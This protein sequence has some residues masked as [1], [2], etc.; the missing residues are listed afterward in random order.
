[1][2]T[3]LHRDIEQAGG[4]WSHEIVPG[5]LGGSPDSRM[6]AISYGGL[7]HVFAQ[8]QDHSTY[9]NWQTAAGIGNWAGWSYLGGPF[10]GDP[11]AVKDLE[12]RANVFVCGLNDG[13]WRVRELPADPWW[14]D[15][16]SLGGDSSGTPA[17]LGNI[18]GT[19]EIFTRGTDG[20][21]YYR[22]QPLALSDVQAELVRAEAD[23]RSVAYRTLLA[24][25]GTSYD[26]IRLV[27]A[28]ADERRTAV[29]DR[30]GIDRAQ[31]RP[32]QLDELFLD[33]TADPGQP[34]EITEAKL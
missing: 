17:V 27:R 2:D 6:A 15:W 26:E 30:L 28:A 32:D 25:V 1:S 10:N 31:S 24:K 16:T 21:A 18:D 7:L 4:G 5:P 9:H 20:A 13:L 8:G 34:G 23:Y 33:P 14:T 19:L 11:V 29:A 12:G 22:K 3:L